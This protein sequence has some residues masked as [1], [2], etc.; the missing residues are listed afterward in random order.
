MV[1]NMHNNFNIGNQIHQLRI[2]RGLSQ[3]QLALS[4]NITPT[5]LGQIERNQ[6]S[7]TI[8]ILEQICT[9]MNVSFSD[10]FDDAPPATIDDDVLTKQLVTLVKNRSNDEKQLIINITKQLLNFNNETK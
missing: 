7:P 10:F 3:E 8:R 4:A 5:Y 9:A 6:K 2:E 1:I